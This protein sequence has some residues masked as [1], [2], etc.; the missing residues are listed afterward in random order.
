MNNIIKTAL[1][2]FGVVILLFI[3]IKAFTNNNSEIFKITS[4]VT[5][6]ERLLTA[7]TLTVPD[8][9]VVVTLTKKVTEFGNINNR[10]EPFG[11]I[12]VGKQVKYINDSNIVA[13]TWL[14]TGGSGDLAY[15]TVFNPGE[16]SWQ[17]ADMKFIGD[18]IDIKDMQ[19]SNDTIVVNYKEHGKDQAMAEEPKVSVTKTYIYKDQKLAEDKT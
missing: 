9:D 11:T 5:A 1:I 8:T 10:K 3:S 16:D 4:G 17:M 12:T 14:N 19:V 7:A 2:I 15:L 18:R 6:R 13:I